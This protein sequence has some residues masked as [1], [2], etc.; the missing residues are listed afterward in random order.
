[1]ANVAA[2]AVLVVA[3]DEPDHHTSDENSVATLSAYCTG[4]D[5]S[6]LQK[7]LSL[8]YPDNPD[9][10]VIIKSTIKLGNALELRALHEF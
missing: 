5:P 8:K 6:R 2:A 9:T 1:M 10:L 7:S 3:V 4:D